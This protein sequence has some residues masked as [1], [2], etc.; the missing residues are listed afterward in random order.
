MTSNPI[1]EIAFCTDFSDNANEAF[2]TAKELVN[3]FGAHLHIVHV[4][5]TPS[6][7]I[8]EMYVP[9]EYDATTVERVSQTAEGTIEELY[10]SKL[11]KAQGCS[12][13]LLSGHPASEIIQLVKEKGINL[14]VM[15][16][17]GLT[18]LA[19]ILFGSTADR[20]VRKASCSVLTVKCP[21]KKRI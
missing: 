15:G 12:V 3:C 5:V 6:A 17:H 19:H 21:E 10:V 13:H 20:V 14:I 7:P 8:G 2:F 9:M 16:S 11:A 18:G 4:M 1:K